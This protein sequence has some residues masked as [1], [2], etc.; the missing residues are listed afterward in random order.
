MVFLFLPFLMYAETATE[1]QGKIQDKTDQINKLEAE[2]AAFS[3]ELDKTATESQTLQNAIK[4]LDLT[5]KK[6]SSSI[7]L[8]QQKINKSELSIKELSSGIKDGQEKIDVNKQALSNLFRQVDTMQ[9]SSFIELALKYENVGDV[10]N[11]I[12][13]SSYV[14]DSIRKKSSEITNLVDDLTERKNKVQAEKVNLENYQK[15][16]KGQKLAIAETTKQKNTLLADTKNKEQNYKNIIS[17][18]EKKILEA[19]KEL[20]DI[21]SALHI[22]ID[23]SSYPT[24]RSG[25]LSWPLDKIFITQLF[26]KT[27]DSNRLYVSGSHNGVDFRASMGTRL[28]APLGGTIVG[29]GNTDIYPGCYSYGKWV[30]IKHPNGISSVFGHLSSV[31]VTVGQS[32]QTGDII[33]YTGNTGYST[34]PHLHVSLFVTQG[35]RIEQYTQSHGCKQAVIPLADVKAYLDPMQYFPTYKI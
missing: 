11:E 12:D 14:Q 29:T 8:T 35:V 24:G 31:A 1:L 20:F 27:V 7:L 21:E 28:K 4:T 5:A 32:V 17:D 3:K 30:M 15:D 34:G 33:G 2:I 25:I 10:W 23:R 18:R 19:Q 9:H 22:A 6:I 26:G 13:K 16:L